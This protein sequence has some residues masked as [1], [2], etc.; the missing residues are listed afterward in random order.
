MRTIDFRS[1]RWGHNHYFEAKDDGTYYGPC[2]VSG[3]VSVGD[4]LVW[5]TNYGHAEAEVLDAKHCGDPSDMYF[6]KS[7]IV[8][9]IANPDIVS[10]EELDRS[11][12]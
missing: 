6:V 9:R 12:A 2:W 8:R 1:T 4:T 11:F 10:Q 5:K 7:K 3:G